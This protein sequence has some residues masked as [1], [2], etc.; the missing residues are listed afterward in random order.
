[1]EGLKASGGDVGDELNV[2]VKKLKRKFISSFLRKTPSKLDV[3][4]CWRFV[5]RPRTL[6]EAPSFVDPSTYR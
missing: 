5:S 1:M 4:V 3:Q 2:K 6:F